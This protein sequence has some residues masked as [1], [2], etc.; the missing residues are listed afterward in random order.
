[1]AAPGVDVLSSFPGGSYSYSSGTSMAGPH[2]VGA[3]ALLWSANPDLI[4][5]IDRTEALLTSTAQPYD[6]SL[7]GTPTCGDPGQIPN[8]VTGYGLVDVFAAV[9]AA[10]AD[11]L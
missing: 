4:G 7:F 9:E 11:T 2:V 5:D 10:L 1:M 8:N 3:V 6:E